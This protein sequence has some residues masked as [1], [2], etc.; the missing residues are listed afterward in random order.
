MPT[1]TGDSTG[2][3]VAPPMTGE[4]GME[5]ERNTI[6]HFPKRC[7]DTY[8]GPSAF[9]EIEN[10]N[11]RDFLIARLEHLSFSISLLLMLSSIFR[12]DK[13]VFYN[14]IHSYSQLILLP[15]GFQDATPDDYDNM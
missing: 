6:S 7:S 4:Q 1:A 10:V 2:T 9:S 8:H 3:R 13:L 15:W 5:P 11:V 12:K 14:S